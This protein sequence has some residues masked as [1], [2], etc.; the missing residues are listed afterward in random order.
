MAPSPWKLSLAPCVQLLNGG[1][2]DLD[3]TRPRHAITATFL[4]DATENAAQILSQKHRSDLLMPKRLFFAK[5]HRCE[6]PPAVDK[7][8]VGKRKHHVGLPVNAGHNGIVDGLQHAHLLIKPEGSGCA[9]VTRP[10]IHLNTTQAG[11]GLESTAN[12]SSSLFAGSP[13]W[14]AGRSAIGKATSWSWF[15]TQLARDFPE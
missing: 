5:H 4:V 2:L 1:R 8:H 13:W 14:Y 9:Y 7:D 11:M 10:C 3:G 12:T 15:S 6:D